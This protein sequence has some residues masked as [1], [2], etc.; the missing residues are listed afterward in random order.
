[1]YFCDPG[2]SFVTPQLKKV[3]EVWHTKRGTRTLPGRPDFDI[4]DLSFALPN[5]AVVTLVRDPQQ[6]RFQV[7]LM[8]SQLDA[9]VGSMTGKFIDEALPPSI[10]GKWTAIW[11]DA[12]DN[13][14]ARRAVGQVEIGGKNYYTFEKFCAPLAADNEVPDSLLIA[15]YYHARTGGHLDQNDVSRRLM[16]ELE[17]RGT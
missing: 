14:C 2:L 7:R 1:M 3:C 11:N 17:V 16:S 4:R 5:V 8:G 10:A 9:Y 13:K 15:T 6:T 12:I